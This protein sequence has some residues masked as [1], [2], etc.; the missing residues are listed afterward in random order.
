MTYV[1]FQV[2]YECTSSVVSAGTECTFACESGYGLNTPNT[3]YQRTITRR[4]QDD[5]TWTGSI[6]TCSRRCPVFGDPG[7]LYELNLSMLHKQFPN[8]I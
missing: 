3:I 6:A 5:G 8:Q 1:A 7:R 2:N 4:C